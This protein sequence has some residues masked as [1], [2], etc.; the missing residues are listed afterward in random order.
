MSI[1]YL[2]ELFIM[3]M[4]TGHVPPGSLRRVLEMASILVGLIVNIICLSILKSVII[5]LNLASH[6]PPGSQRRV[7]KFKVIPGPVVE[8]IDIKLDINC[9]IG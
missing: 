1:I 6:A 2:V 3:M 4:M 9:I 8:V 7:L 5:I